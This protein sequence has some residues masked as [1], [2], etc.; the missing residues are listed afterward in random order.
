VIFDAKLYG[1]I[2]EAA[3]VTLPSDSGDDE[4]DPP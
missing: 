1:T 3:A 4:D 2:E